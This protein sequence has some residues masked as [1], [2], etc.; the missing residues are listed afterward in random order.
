[1]LTNSALLSYTI[2]TRKF[3]SSKLH[4]EGL[5]TAAALLK[6]TAPLTSHAPTAP[7]NSDAIPT[8]TGVSRDHPPLPL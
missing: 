4:V 5:E 6:L 3:G 8:V 1:M 2:H 7:T